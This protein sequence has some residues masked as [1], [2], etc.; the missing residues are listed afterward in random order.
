MPSSSEPRIAIGPI[1]KRR[2][3]VRKPS[4]IRDFS[5]AKRISRRDAAD[6]RRPSISMPAPMVPPIIKENNVIITFCVSRASFIPR[7]IVNIPM[8]WN[9]TSETLSG[10][11][12]FSIMPRLV[13]PKTAITLIRVPFMGMSVAS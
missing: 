4:A 8:P 9:A 1:Q 12:F 2:V 5:V 3:A 10:M 11:R 6:S 13:P 7:K